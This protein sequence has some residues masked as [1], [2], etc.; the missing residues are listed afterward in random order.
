MD[1]VRYC[2]WG[3]PDHREWNDEKVCR[4]I[5]LDC[6]DEVFNAYLGAPRVSVVVTNE[7]KWYDK[8]SDEDGFIAFVVPLIPRIK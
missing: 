3:R 8:G 4:P 5:I 1:E 6:A 7:W 2:G